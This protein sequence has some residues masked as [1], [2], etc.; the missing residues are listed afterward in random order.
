LQRKL[1]KSR[2]W[3]S[4]PQFWQKRLKQIIS[5]KNKSL[6]SQLLL[7]ISSR[8]TKLTPKFCYAVMKRLK[9]SKKL[10]KG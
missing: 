1:K 4:K 3:R 9:C 7:K 2:C 10:L 8:P 6:C 5:R